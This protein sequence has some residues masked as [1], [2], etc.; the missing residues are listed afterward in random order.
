MIGHLPVVGPFHAPAHLAT[1]SATPSSMDTPGGSAP[2]TL[3][4]STPGPHRSS[5]FA[6]IFQIRITSY[7]K[8]IL[9]RRGWAE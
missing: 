2:R 6:G 8:S 7:R 3:S 5:R 9:P 1:T 4:G